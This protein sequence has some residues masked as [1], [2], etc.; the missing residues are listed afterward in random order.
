MNDVV[1]RVERRPY[2]EALL[3]Y[4]Q[5]HQEVVALAGDLTVSCEVD[6]FRDVLPERFLNC[7][8][9][10]Q[11]M[12]GIAGGL[13]RGGMLPIVHTFGV[14]ATRRPLDQVQ[15]AIA[16][17]RARVRIMGF[18]PGLTTP[19]GPTHQAIDDVAI[20]RTLPGLQVFDLADATEI[21]SALEAL[22]EVDGPVYCRVLRG[23]VPVLFE[24][25]LTCEGVRVLSRGL[26]LCLV[27]AGVATAEALRAAQALRA[28]G[29][30]VAHVHLSRLKPFPHEICT[31]V[32]DAGAVITLE[33]HLVTGGLGSAVAEMMAEAGIGRPLVRLGLQDTY[34]VGGSQPYLFSR[35]ELDAQAVL[36]AA[37]E[38]LGERFEVETETASRTG[39]GDRG[40]QEAL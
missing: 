32:S 22:H 35:Y 1:T 26:D 11:N 20:M 38:L 31:A 23:D 15:M 14:F 3:A 29:V 4:G 25:P 18:L 2:A 33:N 36:Q 34:A 16:L 6:A 19:G 5:A 13:A 30:S 8:M 9:A 28:R 12:M 21:R 40:R 39:P 7:G 24:S 37:G 27:S 10:E 17:P